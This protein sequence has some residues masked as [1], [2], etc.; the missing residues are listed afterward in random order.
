MEFLGVGPLELMFI[1]LLVLLVFGPKDIARM[2]RSFGHFLNRL[3]RSENYKIMQKTSEELRNLPNRL[4]QEARLEEELKQLE[5]VKRE[6]NDAGQSIGQ[7]PAPA[8]KPY[9][10]WTQ[11]VPP[12]EPPTPSQPPPPQDSPAA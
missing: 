6:L 8:G 5:E 7:P 12:A 2:A 11:E 1:L 3:Y 10:A 9:Q 4:A